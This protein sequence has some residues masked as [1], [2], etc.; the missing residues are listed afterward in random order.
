MAMDKDEAFLF[1]DTHNEKIIKQPADNR[2][3][4]LTVNGK[5][6]DIDLLG[7]EGLSS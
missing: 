7:E 4:N 6:I 3:S 1:I 2:F 5:F